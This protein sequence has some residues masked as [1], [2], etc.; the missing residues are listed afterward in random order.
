MVRATKRI[1]EPR[2]FGICHVLFDITFFIIIA[3][4]QNIEENYRRCNDP[5]D[6]GW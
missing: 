5:D 6:E 2:L 1:R 4:F 3:F